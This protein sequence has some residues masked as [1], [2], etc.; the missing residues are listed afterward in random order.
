MIAVD[1]NLLVRIL[2][3]DP[4]QPAQVDA[5]RALASKARQVF[6]PLVVQVETVWVL[7]S[8]YGLPKEKVAHALEQLEVNDAFALE[9]ENLCH[10]AL[11]LYRSSNADYADCVILTNCRTRGLRLHTFD[12]RLGKLDGATLLR[13]KG[14]E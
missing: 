5:A 13:A 6:V 8:G 14:Q 11:E 12:K 3:D 1:T 4:G 10:S 7:E 9:D 2:V